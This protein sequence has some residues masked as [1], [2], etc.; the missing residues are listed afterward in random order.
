VNEPHRSRGA[1]RTSGSV[2]LRPDL[3]ADAFPLWGWRAQLALPPTFDNA[4]FTQKSTFSAHFSQTKL[5]YAYIAPVIPD[6]T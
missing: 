5:I 2:R 1:V 3:G 4:L 6:Y